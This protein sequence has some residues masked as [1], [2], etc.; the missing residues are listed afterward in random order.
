MLKRIIFDMKVEEG[1]LKVMNDEF[2]ENVARLELALKT[3]QA[4]VNQEVDIEEETGG[5]E[6]AEEPKTT[7]PALHADDHA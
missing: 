1:T 5:L 4:K 7:G 6:P 2:R 3:T